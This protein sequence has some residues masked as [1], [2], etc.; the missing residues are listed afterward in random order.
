[1][2][3][4]D[5][6]FL[7]QDTIVAGQKTYTTDRLQVTPPNSNTTTEINHIDHDCPNCRTIGELAIE[8][9][10]DSLFCPICEY[11]ISFNPNTHLASGVDIDDHPTDTH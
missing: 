10:S 3:T 7:A 11:R 9:R 2:T 6:K 4:S 1:M 8:L 5:F